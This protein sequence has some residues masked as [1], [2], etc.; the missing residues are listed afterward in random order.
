MQLYI[1]AP[2]PNAKRVQMF[3]HE[4][5]VTIPCTELNFE[6]GEHRSDT[7]LQ[8]NPLAQ[9][10]VLELD[11][12]KCIAESLTICLYIEKRFPENPLLGL[13]TEEQVDIDMWSR[14]V[15]HELFIPAVEYGHHTSPFFKHSKWQNAEFAEHCELKIHKM[16][17]IL[18]KELA[19]KT[20]LCSSGFS[21]VDISAYI[22]MDLAKL[23]SLEIPSELSH[24][25]RWYALVKERP[26][27]RHHGY[28][29]SDSSL[30]G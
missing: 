20:Y 7:F 29:K 25:Q 14:R 12:G 11:D 17:N 8:K 22:A 24:L 6:K 3:L 19:N 26:S 30:T 21:I 18:D 27:A 5:G 2:S 28:F 10:P 16:W 15:E 1:E 4:K 23:W 13:S 9:V